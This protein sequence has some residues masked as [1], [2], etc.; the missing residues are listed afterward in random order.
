MQ[1]WNLAARDLG[2]DRGTPR[3]EFMAGIMSNVAQ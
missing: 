1:R 3:G 2:I